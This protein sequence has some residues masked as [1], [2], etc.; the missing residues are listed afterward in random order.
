SK[1]EWLHMV[2]HS[3]GGDNEPDNL[4]AGTFDANTAMIPFERGVMAEQSKLKLGESIQYDVTAILVPGT[5]VATSITVSVRFPKSIGRKDEAVT[6]QTTVN[7]KLTKI[8]YELITYD[9]RRQSG[10]IYTDVGRT[11]GASTSSTP[12][13]PIRRVQ[14][15]FKVHTAT[16]IGNNC[17]LDTLNQLRKGVWVTDQNA[18]K[19]MRETLKAACPT[20]GS[21]SMLDIYG[22]EGLRL[23]NDLQ[24]RL[25]VVQL[26]D[27]NVFV[28]PVRG[29]PSD[30]LHYVMH[31]GAHFSPLE[32]KP[33]MNHQHVT[34][35]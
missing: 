24:M 34:N 14:R 31:Q 2:G 8:Q 35:L 17:L 33:G 12:Q 23:I 1:W 25:C 16:G 7:L 22:A 10:G 15:V 20:I 21:T 4:V 3:V 26:R 32:L 9:A 5:H 30:A 27:G 29:D 11:G 18:V 13:L 19:T 28:G 6:F